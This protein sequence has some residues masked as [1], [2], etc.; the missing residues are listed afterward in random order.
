MISSSF[1]S[2]E[3]LGLDLEEDSPDITTEE[4]SAVTLTEG[5]DDFVKKAKEFVATYKNPL[6]VTYDL[7]TRGGILFCRVVV[8]QNDTNP[9]S[10]MFEVEW[11][12][13]RSS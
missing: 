13:A 9:V 5:G 12:R 4:M 3:A 2:P 6:K 7:R 8:L 1:L 11:L 10:R